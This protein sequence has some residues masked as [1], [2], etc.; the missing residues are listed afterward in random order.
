MGYPFARAAAGLV[1]GCVLASASAGAVELPGKQAELPALGST[2]YFIGQWGMDSTDCS[3]GE[4]IV[5]FATGAFAAFNGGD[6][7]EVVGTWRRVD[8]GIEFAFA[9][10]QSPARTEGGLATT[11]VYGPDVVQIAAEFVP[12][13]EVTLNRCAG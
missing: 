13:E 1:A 2:E 5:F 10:P 12:N 3:Q 8:G 9:T 7:V 11:V 6:D 4:S